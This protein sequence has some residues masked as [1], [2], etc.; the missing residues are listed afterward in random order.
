MT[1]EQA[2][3]A[4]SE[5]EA[6]QLHSHLG[7]LLGSAV[8][9]GSGPEA[10]DSCLQKTTSTDALVSALVD[11]S[12]GTAASELV[13]AHQGDELTTLYAYV[14]L[15]RRARGQFPGVKLPHSLLASVGEAAR[16][17]GETDMAFEMISLLVEVDSSSLVQ[18]VTTYESI[19]IAADSLRKSLG[20]LV[21]ETKE[22]ADDSFEAARTRLISETER[23]YRL[24]AKLL[25]VHRMLPHSL[26][27]QIVK[28]KLQTASGLAAAKA[29]HDRDQLLHRHKHPDELLTDIRLGVFKT[30]EGLVAAQ[31]QHDNDRLIRHRSKPNYLLDDIDSK[32]FQTDLGMAAAKLQ[33]DTA[34]L[35]SR[36]QRPEELFND[37]TAGRFRTFEGIDVAKEQQDRDRLRAYG[38][39]KSKLREDLE[40]RRYLTAA[41][42]AEAQRLLAA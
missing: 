7:V 16:V 42:V 26:L 28:G 25:E 38:R 23:P 40:A 39:A 24:D 14:S 32:K 18:G 10:E 30:T 13:V 15:I 1:V 20:K 22:A 12:I 17:Q 19:V 29:Q 6:L 21:Q 2:A 27:E 36:Q 11:P 31:M 35:E 33:Q 5:S 37:I 34:R 41:G 8:T 9:I 4:L 3:R